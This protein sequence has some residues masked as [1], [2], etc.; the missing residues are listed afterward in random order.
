MRE[1]KNCEKNVGNKRTVHF[2]ANDCVRKKG[3]YESLGY[4][5]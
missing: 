4:L 2:S 1:E 3:K 5:S